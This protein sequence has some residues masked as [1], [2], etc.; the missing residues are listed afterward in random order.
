MDH[1]ISKLIFFFIISYA[2]L[3]I[4]QLSLIITLPSFFILSSFFFIIF[5]SRTTLSQ[6]FPALTFTATPRCRD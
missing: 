1:C 2:E 5:V 6:V 4:L 3:I